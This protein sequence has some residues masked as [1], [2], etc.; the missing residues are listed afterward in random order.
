MNITLT[1]LAA[2]VTVAILTLYE[3]SFVLAGRRTPDRIARSAQAALRAEWF[4]ALAE[5][6]GSE[7][8]VVQTLRN[9]LMAATA[10]HPPRRS[11]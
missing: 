8:L 3:I 11:A 6:K 7:I 10:L 2:S 1:W 5:Q 9:S 4:V